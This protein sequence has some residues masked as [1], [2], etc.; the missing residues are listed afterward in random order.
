MITLWRAG[1]W[2]TRAAMLTLL[3]LALG[4]LLVPALA[5]TDPLA[6]GDGHRPAAILQPP[7]QP[8]YPEPAVGVEHHFDDR[9]VFEEAGDGGAERGA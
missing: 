6:I 5:R 7:R 4:A 8:V 1:T 2:R 9:R 3:A